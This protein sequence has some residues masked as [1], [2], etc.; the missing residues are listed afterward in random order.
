[1]MMTSTTATVPTIVNTKVHPLCYWLQEKLQHASV[2]KA[3]EAR[4]FGGK[5]TAISG[6]ETWIAPLENPSLKALLLVELL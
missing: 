5:Q 6:K 3:L 4:L 2:L 1:M